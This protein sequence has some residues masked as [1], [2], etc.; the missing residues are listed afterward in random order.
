VPIEVDGRHLRVIDVNPFRNVRR[1]DINHLTG[2][3]LER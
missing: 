1:V 3:Q 2:G